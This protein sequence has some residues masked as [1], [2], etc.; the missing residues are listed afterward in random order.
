MRA[1]ANSHWGSRPPPGFL[2]EAVLA[3]LT[4]MSETAIDHQFV[5]ANGLRFH[6][7]TCGEGQHLAL[8]LHGFPECWYSW[9]FQL[10]ML[11]RL[12]YRAWAPDLRGYGE[13]DRPLR[14]ED[15]AIE[16]LLGDVAGLIDESGAR[17]V[18]LLAHDWGAII[19]WYFAMRRQRPLERLVIMN[20]PHPARMEQALR[21]WRQLARS[22]YVLFFQLPRLPELLLRT[23]NYRA[24]GDAFRNMAVDKS[25]FPDEVLRV[26]RDA[27]ARPGALTAMVNY[28][29]ALV[30]GGGGARQRALGYAQIQ[31][32]TLMIWGERDAALGK[33]T[34]FGTQAL[35][36]NLTIRY[37]PE[38]SHWVQQ[39]APEIVNAMI[40]AWLAGQPV[41]E[42]PRRG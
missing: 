8:C 19:A 24:I 9:R 21:S 31:T 27:A 20:V 22:W 25:R 3:S 26:Y 18:T 6:V 40:E 37:L 42:A 33:E 29:R 12:G 23:R 38:V 7:A 34:T 10:P 5:R 14:R 41:P 35:V 2:L 39:E 11:A 16:N 17:S 13:S 28:Y 15:Y 36:P 30:R 32:P 4:A 1:S